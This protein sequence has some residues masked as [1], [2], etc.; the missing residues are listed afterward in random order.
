MARLVRQVRRLEM[1]RELPGDGISLVPIKFFQ[2]P[3]DVLVE[4]GCL[5]GVEAVVEI[6]LHQGVSEAV[7][8]EPPLPKALDPLTVHQPV[9]FLQSLAQISDG[10]RGGKRRPGG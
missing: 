5:D 3:A 4:E 7:M 9:L 2:R 8:R 10:A 1:P 6:A